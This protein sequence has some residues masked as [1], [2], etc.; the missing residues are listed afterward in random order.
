M[1]HSPLVQKRGQNELKF[2]HKLV[3]LLDRFTIKNRETQE[4]SLNY[5]IYGHIVSSHIQF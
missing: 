1:Q 3:Q 2:E 5:D 4:K